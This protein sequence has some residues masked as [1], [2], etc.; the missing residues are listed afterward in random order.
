MLKI[1][2]I[3]LNINIFLLSLSYKYVDSIIYILQKVYYDNVCIQDIILIYT[4]ITK[5]IL[6]L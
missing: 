3:M 1:I 4:N 6:M 2:I 5:S